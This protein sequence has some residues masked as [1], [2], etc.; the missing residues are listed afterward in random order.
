[1]SFWLVRRQAG[2]PVRCRSI[3]VTHPAFG[4]IGNRDLE[5]EFVAANDQRKSRIA[6]LDVRIAYQACLVYVSLPI[7]GRIGR[8][9]RRL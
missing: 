6:V 4:G 7:L 1:M 2:R 5:R 8:H 3:V 9:A